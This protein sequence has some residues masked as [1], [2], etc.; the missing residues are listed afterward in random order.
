MDTTFIVLGL[1]LLVGFYMAW[2][3]GASDVANAMGTSVGSHALT[4]KQA[5]FVAAIFE[6]L[7]AFLAGGHVTNTIKQGIIDPLSFASDPLL[8]AW[9]MTAALL[10]TGIWLQFASAKGL[11]VSTTNSLV[12]ALIGFGLV[13][14]GP[15]AIK[16]DELSY[17][18]LSWLISP[19]LGGLIALL[20]FFAIRKYILDSKEPLIVTQRYAPLILFGVILTLV[21]LFA[22]KN[23][24][25][26]AVILSAIG[27]LVFSKTIRKI[28]ASSQN[29]DDTLSRIERVFAWLQIITACFMAFA[30][31]SND[32][33]NAIGPVAAV[34][35]IAFSHHIVLTSQIP[36]WLLAMGGFGIVL[37]LATYGRK[38]IETIGHSITEITPTRGFA[39]EFGAAFTIL[40]GSH[41]GLPL[42]TTQVLVGAVIG[43]GLARGIAGLNL[44]V[45][46]KILSSW[47]ITIPATC[48][49]S[50]CLNLIIQ[51]F[52]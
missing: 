27:A 47:V 34:I 12:G 3:I 45:I 25:G 2:S 21:S 15:E 30:H 7:G 32:V 51:L 49:V 28:T 42:S 6:F 17:I 13:C 31:G 40:V 8:F 50:A 41:F 29:R 14:R 11:P 48:L 9:G 19:L 52:I 10:S 37:G 18:A 4:I 1:S 22:P 24:L 20:A 39:A 5:I 26:L 46:R 36:W 16:W 44:L 23:Y 35:S 43:V 33:S 38:V